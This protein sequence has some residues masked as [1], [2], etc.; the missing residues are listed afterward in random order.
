MVNDKK[1]MKILQRKKTYLGLILSFWDGVMSL[2]IIKIPLNLFKPL[3]WRH[4]P[5]DVHRNLQFN[6]HSYEQS[7][8][9]VPKMPIH[10]VHCV[11]KVVSNL[12]QQVTN[13]S[14]R[15]FQT[16]N[17]TS[18][19]LLTPDICTEK[20]STLLFAVKSIFPV[21]FKEKYSHHI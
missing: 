1:L 8:S 14:E 4:T 17:P 9:K 15:T 3:K 19:C 10:S 16:F 5:N 20:K 11:V 13:R 7:I 6:T 2:L 12:C 18:M 21:Q